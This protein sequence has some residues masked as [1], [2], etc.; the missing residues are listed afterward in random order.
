MST[1]DRAPKASF[2]LE[3]RTDRVVNELVGLC[4]GVLADGHVNE[5][6]AWFIKDWIER[7]GAFVGRYPFSVIYARLESILRD[8]RID[9]DESADLHDTL[10]RFV[11]GEACDL[12]A[13]T[14]SLASSLPLDQPSPAVEHAGRVFVVTGTFT[15][16]ARSIVADSIQS[17]GGVLANA[18]SKQ[19]HFL[20]IGELGSRDW[21]SSNAGRK[22][23]KAIE[24][25]EQGAQLKIVSEAHWARHL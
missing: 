18:P 10:V 20:V 7:N 4:R 5:Q 21:I 11:G 22:I 24:L 6:E 14:A 17:R 12:E 23:Q 15:H 8:G 3:R 16:G 25:R 1:S 13:E 9:T 19:T 2:T